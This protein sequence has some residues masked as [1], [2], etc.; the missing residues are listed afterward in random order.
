MLL[1][2]IANE[3]RDLLDKIFSALSHPACHLD[4]DFSHSSLSHQLQGS[5]WV[6]P[7]VLGVDETTQFFRGSEKAVDSPVSLLTGAGPNLMTK[8]I[9]QFRKR[10]SLDIEILDRSLDSTVSEERNDLLKC[11]SLPP[12]PIRP[13]RYKCVRKAV[14]QR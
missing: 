12:M 9:G 4:G 1:F 5:N 14:G 7:P 6:E 10:L 8:K 11:A 13:N 3:R 2:A